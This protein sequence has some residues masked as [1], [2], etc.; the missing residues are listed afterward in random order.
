MQIRASCSKLDEAIIYVSCNG[1]GPTRDR[2]LLAANNPIRIPEL[3]SR[4]PCKRR[5]VRRCNMLINH[6]RDITLIFTEGDNCDDVARLSFLIDRDLLP[7]QDVTY[8]S[9]I[10]NRT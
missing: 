1:P 7:T 10:N 9:V 2:L 6:P 8:K 3:M 4:T 5:F